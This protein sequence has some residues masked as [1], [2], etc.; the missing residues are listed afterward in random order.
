MRQTRLHKKFLELSAPLESIPTD[1]E[2][3]I[4]ILK[5]IRLIAYDFYGTLFI[6]GVGDIGIDDGAPDSRLL[7]AAL[8][9]CGIDI[10]QNRAASEGF[11]IYNRIVSR[12]ID[13]LK[14][15]GTE[16]PEPDIRKVWE[17]VLSEMKAKELVQFRPDPELYGLMSVEFEARMNPVWPMPG[18]VETLLSFKEMGMVQGIISNSQFYTPIVLEALSGHSLDQL[19]FTSSLLHWSFEEK[20]KK[21][22]LEFYKRYLKKVAAYDPS[23]K[24]DQILYIGNDMLKD[25]W[26]AH[27]LGMKTALF[28]GDSRSLKWRREDERCKELEPDLVITDLHQISALL[29]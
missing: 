13:Y 22:G 3:T 5:G 15:E 11:E 14:R 28:A 2:P 20:M 25:V 16:N 6:S 27:T 24:P 29:A 8:T 9:G 18:V 26:P 10:I 23:I 19:G 7:S 17:E 4:E 12:E 21:P 1:T